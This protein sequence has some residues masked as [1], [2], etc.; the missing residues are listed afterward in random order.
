MKLDP[1][2]T[3]HKK[4]INSK[5]IIELTVKRKA[6][7]FLKDNTGESLQDLGLNEDFLDI[8]PKAQPIE[9]KIWIN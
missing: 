1:N 6:I 7:K 4:K 5:W 8:T 9:E 2:L 3:P